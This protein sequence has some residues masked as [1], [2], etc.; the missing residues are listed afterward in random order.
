[1]WGWGGGGGGGWT[2]PAPPVLTAKKLNREVVSAGRGVGSYFQV[3]GH[4]KSLTFYLLIRP[5]PGKFDLLYGFGK[6]RGGGASPRFHAPGWCSIL[7][8]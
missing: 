7:S 1:M 2:P 3:G 6:F 8:Q 4:G 5:F